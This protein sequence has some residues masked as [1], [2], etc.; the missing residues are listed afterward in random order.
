MLWA[1]DEH[2]PL[3][4]IRTATL[5]VSALPSN[6]GHVSNPLVGNQLAADPSGRPFFPAA[7]VTYITGISDNAT[8]TDPTYR[9]GDWQ[10]GGRAVPPSDIYGTWKGAVSSG[11]T[12]GVTTDADPAK[13]NWNLGPG[14]DTPSGGFAKLTNQGYGTE[15][16]WN[17]N[18]LVDKNNQPLIS[19]HTYRV[20]VI[21][22]DGDQ[23]KS[24]G[25]V[26][27][28]CMLVTIP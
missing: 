16:R 10:Y 3:L 15:V 6:P 4:G 2:A 23:N 9:A 27:E 1:A 5:P 11:G 21:V 14:S 20:Q 22:H 24:G 25:D 28:A 26:G 18:A 12:N 13:N 17:V 7:F 8:H 19:G